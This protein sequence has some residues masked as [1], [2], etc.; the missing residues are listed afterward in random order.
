MNSTPH[1]LITFQPRDSLDRLFA[2]SIAIKGLDGLFE[3][4]AG[5][6]LLPITP[7]QVETAAGRFA[8]SLIAAWLPDTVSAWAVANAERVTIAGLAFGAYYL[9]AHGLV[10]IVLVAALLR[11]K[12]WAYPV[13]ITVLAGF[14]LF[15]CYE[16]SQRPSV[17]LVVLTVFDVAVIGLTVREYGRQRQRRQQRAIDAEPAP[18]DEQSQVRLSVGARSC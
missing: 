11:N 16:L 13:M 17:G 7:E 4:F 10:K 8:G 14:V 2:V 1:R 6:A 12:L 18:T 15:Q 5:A 3:L 9:L